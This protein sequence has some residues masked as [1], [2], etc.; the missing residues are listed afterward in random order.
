MKKSFDEVKEIV[1]KVRELN[2][3][4][5]YQ[6]RSCQAYSSNTVYL[7]DEDGN[8]L[9]N[10]KLFRSYSTIVALIDIDNQVVYRLGKWS[11]TTS[12]QTTQFSR[13]YYP[14]YEQVQF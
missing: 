11:T 14:M 2:K 9:G 8:H 6:F 13:A 4:I 12:K 5:W 10:Y 7:Y 3:D 1:E